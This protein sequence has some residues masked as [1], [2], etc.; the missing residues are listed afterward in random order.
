[1][2]RISARLS[3]SI[4][5]E[6]FSFAKISTSLVSNLK[7]FQVFNFGCTFPIRLVDIPYPLSYS[8]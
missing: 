6:G 7:A 2:D 8:A 1:M 3:T 5:T 4:M